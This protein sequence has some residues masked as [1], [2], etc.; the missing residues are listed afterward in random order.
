VTATIQRQ[1]A[2]VTGNERL[3]AANGVVLTVLLAVE[4][5]TILSIRGLI[6]AH[7]FVGALLIGPVL[8]KCA[9]TGY[10]FLS[11]Y[12]GRPAYVRRGAPPLLLRVLGP[13]VLLSTLA[14][15]GTG[16]GLVLTLDLGIGWLWASLAAMQLGRFVFLTARWRT[17]AWERVGAE[18]TLR[19][20]LE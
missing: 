7:V 8:L 1:D 17:H 11:Y 3:T 20:V 4:G 13:L 9:S 10:R 15:L 18:L 2:G 5:L 19:P 12:T 16:V 14:V 6:T